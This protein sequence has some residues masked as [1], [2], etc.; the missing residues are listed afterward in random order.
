MAY[1]GARLPLVKEGGPPENIVNIENPRPGR[2]CYARDVVLSWPPRSV[3][4]TQFDR[5]ARRLESYR[6]DMTN[7]QIALCSMPAM[8]PL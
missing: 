8:W 1:Y 2:P 5:V 6:N 7:M 3:P 4:M